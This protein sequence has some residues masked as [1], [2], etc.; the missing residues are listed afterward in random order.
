MIRKPHKVTISTLQA[1]VP[2][3]GELNDREVSTLVGVAPINRDSGTMSGM[4]SILGGRPG[5]L[6]VPASW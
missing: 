3:L 6:C 5:Y 2:E 4:R 1:E